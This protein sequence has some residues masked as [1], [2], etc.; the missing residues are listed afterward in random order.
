MRPFVALSLGL[1]AGISVFVAAAGLTGSWPF[2]LPIGG[3]AGCVVTPW[4]L[5]SPIIA[6]D[7]AACS[8]GLKIV[9]AIATIVAL[10]QLTRLAVFT[11]AP[12]QV[13]YSIV[14]SSTWE[15]SHFC[16]SAYFVAA[17]AADAVP[18]VYD[19]SLYSLPGGDPTGIRKPQMIGPFAVDVYEYPPPFLLLPRALRLLTPDF[20]RFRMLWFGLNCGI[21]LVVM[22]VVAPLLGPAAGTRA[23]LLAPLVWAAIP[24]LSTLQKGNLQTTAVAASMLSMA[25]FERRRWA[26]GGV[27]LA[28]ATA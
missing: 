3:V 24:T 2:A 23:L 9:S 20:M 15:V 25:L 21:L 12:S 19:D 4:F 16:G 8:R 22:V 6:L 28:F 18:N 27:L 5:K 17:R 11:V 7:E 26:S 14:P 10:V 13:G 1:A